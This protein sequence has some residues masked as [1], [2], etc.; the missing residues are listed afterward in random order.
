M[1][2]TYKFRA[3]PT[4]SQSKTIDNQLEICRTLY[5][6]AL[7]LKIDTY[8]ETGKSLSLYDLQNRLKDLKK[9][10]SSLKLVHSQVLQNTQERVDLAFQGFFRRLKTT[11]K[12]GFP[13]F[14]ESGR[15]RSLTYPQSG[16]KFLSK[17]VQLS[18]VGKVKVVFHRPIVGKVKRLSIVKY[19]S[20]KYFLCISVEIETNAKLVKPIKSVGI[21]LGCTHFAVLS[22]GTVIDSP[23]PLRKAKQKLASQ[24][25]KQKTVTLLHERIANKR[26][27][28]LHK[29]ANRLVDTYDLISVEDL[30]VKQISKV[31][32]GFSSDFRRTIADNG[33]STFINM[34]KYK[35][36]IAGKHVV[37]IDPKYT[38]QTCSKCGSVKKMELSERSYH[39][40]ACGLLL[41]RDLNA[42]H[43][44]LRLGV[45][46][47]GV[48]P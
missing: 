46:S 6:G 20:G 38:S 26:I 36:V 37:L 12:P 33:W 11:D 32:K 10:D 4:K 39:C 7:K 43:N 47:F 28:F 25:N 45:Q 40:Q 44:I 41:D 21:D 2:I 5:N 30:D 23:K 9:T 35:A 18:K 19:P 42:S 13:K 1:Q 3:Y 16:F 27:D 8:K 48:S 29:L 15:L 14:K 34:L 24:Q 22:D 31:K 17:T